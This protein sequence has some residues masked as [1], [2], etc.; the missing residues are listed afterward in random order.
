M[1][2]NFYLEVAAFIVGV[3]LWIASFSKYKL[4]D[5]RG[6]IYYQMVRTTT[7]VTGCNVLSYLIIRNNVGSLIFV[8]EL[9][10]CMSFLLMVGIWMYL[11]LYLTETIQ[12]KN[13]FSYSDIIKTGFPLFLIML[14]LLVNLGNHSLYDVIMVEDSMQIVFNAWYK[15]PYILVGLCVVYYLILYIK[16]RKLL[17]EKYQ[18]IL[19]VIPILLVIGYCLQYRFKA[20]AVLGYTYSISL[21]LMYIYSYSRIIKVDS[22]TRLP[23]GAAFEK[24]L[25]Y[26]IGQKQNMTVALI[27]LDDFKQVNREYGYQ[28]GNAFLR[29]VAKYIKTEAPKS[30]VARHSGDKFAIVFDDKTCENVEEWCDAFLERFEQVWEIGKLRHKMSVCV[31]LVEYPTMADSVGQIFDLLEQMNTYGKQNKRN[32]CIVCNDTFKDN[33]KRRLRIT[34]MLS[35]VLQNNKMYLEYQPILNVQKNAF[36]RAE[37]LLRL[38]DEELGNIESSEFFA[39]AEEHGYIND[40]GY[41]LFEQVCQYIKGIKDSGKTVPTISFNFSRQQLMAEDLIEKI[42][43]FLKKYEIDAARIAFEL[44]ESVF[45][46]QYNT[47]KE[48]VLRLSELGCKFYLDGFGNAFLDMTR[49]ME[50]PFEVIKIN[51][52]MLKA[53][54]HDEAMY[55]LV[56]AMIAVFEENNKLILGDG[57]DSQQLKEKADLLFMDYLQGDYL[58]KTVTAE[59]AIV[60]FAKTDVIEGM[61]NVDAMLDELLD[62]EGEVME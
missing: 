57:I 35:E 6:K 58:C 25:K 44:P 59:Q 5:M 19:L 4:M 28:K 39:I 48:Q 49:M 17:S 46:V 24:M 12:G 8:S 9:V 21:L 7:V 27:S 41:V 3:I 16:N 33:M 52:A 29:L 15:I 36:T 2:L 51:K 56:S 62:T 37:A 14:I 50:M 47:V 60:E 22:L 13:S 26:R 34:E 32:Q 40:I 20:T 1:A 54:E 53:A 43:G 42:E 10:V 30:C 38:Q 18:I 31:S 23:D 11:N 55:L 45:S 61:P